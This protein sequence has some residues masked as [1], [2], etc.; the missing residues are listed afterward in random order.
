MKVPTEKPRQMPDSSN[1]GRSDPPIRGS[2]DPPVRPRDASSLIVTRKRG[3]KLYVLMGRRNSAARFMPGVFVF[4]GGAVSA[5]DSQMKPATELDPA[6]TNLMGVSHSHPRA[7]ALAL[8][9]IRETWEETGMLLGVSGEFKGRPA[10]PWQSIVKLGMVP[11]LQHLR[12]VGR[13]ITP[14][15][16]KIRF[17]ARFFMVDAAWLSGNLQGDGE[18]VEIGWWNV[19]QLAAL[20]MRNITRFMLERAIALSRGEADDRPTPLFS[21][22]GRRQVTWK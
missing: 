6:Y 2:G 11:D 22:R 4:P 5:A 21:W 14:S 1:P 13:A 16:S 17:H 19:D 18:L 20:E 7:R 3:S 8:T 9:A 10:P 12:Y 15:F